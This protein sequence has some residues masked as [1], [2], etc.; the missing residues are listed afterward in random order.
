MI[1]ALVCPCKTFPGFAHIS[2]F[3][4]GVNL[5]DPHATSSEA[6]DD[7]ATILPAKENG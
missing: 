5:P 2:H 4:F 3:K 7:A 1:D 6:S